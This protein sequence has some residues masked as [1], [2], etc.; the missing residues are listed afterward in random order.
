MLDGDKIKFDRSWKSSKEAN[1][2]HWTRKKPQN[3]IQFAFRN[4]WITFNKIL[5]KNKLKQKRV[6]EVGCGRGSLS[7]YFADN[8]W[9]CTLLDSSAKAISIA[10]NYFNK[11]KLKASYL[12]ADCKKIPYPEKSFDLVFSIGLLEHFK[13][14]EKIINEQI[15]VLDKGGLFIG[16]IVP[17]IKNNIQDQYEWI[18]NIFTLLTKSNNNKNRKKKIYRTNYMSNFYKQILKKNN[19]M[20]IKSSGIYPVPMISISKS[21]PFTLMD[22][23]IEKVIVNHFEKLLYEDFNNSWLCN[24]KKGQAILVWGTKK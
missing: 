16:Y 17:E 2:S 15:R 13:N 23:N 10:K 11:N 19:L 9:D 8:K 14:P 12:V 24:E 4:H 1:Y 20:N 18:N 21:F 7:A 5:K 3:Q 6:L 22:I